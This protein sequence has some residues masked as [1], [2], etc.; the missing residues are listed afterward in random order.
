M[1]FYSKADPPRAERAD[2]ADVWRRVLDIVV[3]VEALVTFGPLMLLIAFA[4][5]LESG[6][7]I[8]FSQNRLGL[9]G[10]TFRMY[11]F[12]KF[13]PDCGTNGSPLTLEGD[14]R[15]TKVGRFL[16]ATKLD[17]LPQFWNVL[18]G[19]MSI[20]GPRPETLV[21]ADCFSGGFERVLNHKPGILG[22]TQV[23][24]RNE[25]SLYPTDSDPAEFYRA[26]LFPTKALIDV[27]YYDRRTLLSDIAWIVSGV[28]AIVGWVP[29]RT[30]SLPPFGSTPLHAGI[31]ARAP[32]PAQRSES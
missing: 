11:K 19:D 8:L 6:G 30:S 29:A 16:Q 31:A 10:R 26:V 15:L 3:A 9:N 13:G 14:A 1:A 5:W 23:A 32:V 25:S 12:R 17:E 18:R 4:I 21:F 24:F 28:L 22:P 20:V 27:D 7:P 2:N